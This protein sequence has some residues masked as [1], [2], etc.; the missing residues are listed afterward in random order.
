MWT[1]IQKKDV[2]SFLKT[3]P[4]LR[5]YWDSVVLVEMLD[6]FILP[7]L[8]YSTYSSQYLRIHRGKNP[9]IE[10]C[11]LKYKFK[12]DVKLR[13]TQ[14]KASKAVLKVYKKMS[15]VNG[16][17]KLPPGAGKTVLATYLATVLNKRTII[18]V[19][20]VELMKQ[21]K[22]AFLNFTTITE[23]DFGLIQQDVAIVDKDV[24]FT[25]SQTL[26]AKIK[27]D[28]MSIYNI[29]S[30]SNIDLV[31][32]DEVHA[33]SASGE[34]SKCSILFQ[35]RNIIGLSATPFHVDIH[36]IL[37]TNT[38]GPILYSSN[39]Y[40]MTPAYH[41][42]HYKSNL[43]KIQKRISHMG[44]YTFKKAAYN[45]ALCESESFIDIVDN[46]IRLLRQKDHVIFCIFMTKKQ[47]DKI[48]GRLTKRGIS[49]RCYHG[50]SREID[51]E[52]DKI[53]LTTYALSGK[54]FDMPRL[55]ALLLGSPLAGK[56][57]LIQTIGR[58]VRSYKD[59][60]SPVVIDL[61]DE[62]IDFTLEEL[63]IKKGVVETEFEN[64][65]VYDHA[66]IADFRKEL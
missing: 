59:K 5:D 11:K 41:L 18:V 13:P 27:N 60:Q 63:D 55:S 66:T 34:Y 17:L 19:D 46:I 39:Q 23:D 65:D 33:T 2:Q 45:K 37:M 31:I 49:H 48:S 57:S 21:W 8:F 62:S 35:T 50:E 9:N 16:I 14:V 36:E 20:S 52:T 26:T 22:E 32:Y 53:I 44:N 40:E 58:V 15:Y 43:E 51:K 61:I 12:S 3:Q 4:V 30:D 29:I 54:G 6:F 56:K 28:L 38:I 10:Q 25:M 1:Y 47:I 42:I 64:I 24:I 7:R